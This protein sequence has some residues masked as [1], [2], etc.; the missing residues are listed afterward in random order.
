MLKYLEEAIK[1][2]LNASDLY[3]MFCRVFPEDYSF[4]WKLSIEEEDHASLL[5]SAYQFYKVQDLPFEITQDDLNRLIEFNNTFDNIIKEFESLPTRRHAFQIAISLEN[6]VGEIH[7]QKFMTDL[8][9]TDKLSII[10]K[11]LNRD[12]INHENRIKEYI[13]RNRI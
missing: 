11:K 4:W 10:F 6:S 13:S 5:R 1:S 3:K 7:Y 12:D 9:K 2:E 8:N